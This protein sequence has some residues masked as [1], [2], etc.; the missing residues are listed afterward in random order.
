M[1]TVWIIESKQEK[2]GSKDLMGVKVRKKMGEA[3]K[4]R[5]QPS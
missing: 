4:Y 5:S 3:M 2:N 1:I